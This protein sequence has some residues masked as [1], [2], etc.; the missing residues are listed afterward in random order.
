MDDNGPVDISVSKAKYRTPKPKGRFRADYNG[1]SGRHL[2]N[3][4]PPVG[5][6]RRPKR[7]AFRQ[8]LFR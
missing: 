8:G 7:G 4:T 2:T 5:L 1:N 3:G 6:R